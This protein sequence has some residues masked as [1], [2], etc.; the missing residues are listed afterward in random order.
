MC[1]E[2]IASYE[3]YVVDTII[4]VASFSRER[5]IF[6]LQLRK[7]KKE[8]SIKMENGEY[9][10][11]EKDG[12]KCGGVQRRGTGMCQGLCTVLVLSWDSDLWNRLDWSGE[13]ERQVKG[14]ELWLVDRVLVGAETTRWIQQV[15][16]ERTSSFGYKLHE[17]VF[18]NRVI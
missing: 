10:V 4:G 1:R 5:Y 17:F 12:V 6:F 8:W 9:A 2:L 3:A 13:R 11:G 16:G 7:E 18:F 14:T 15:G